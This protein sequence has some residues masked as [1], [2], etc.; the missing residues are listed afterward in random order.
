MGD[1]DEDHWSDDYGTCRREGFGVAALGCTNTGPIGVCGGF[2][3]LF[4][5]VRACAVC[6]YVRLCFYTYTS[7]SC[8]VVVIPVGLTKKTAPEDEA[9]VMST[10]SAINTT[11]RRFGIRSTLDVRHYTVGWRFADHELRG[12]PIRLEVGPRDVKAGKVAGCRRVDG[13]K[14]ELAL[15]GVDVADAPPAES[16]PPVATAVDAAVAFAV[17]AKGKVFAEAVL[18]A[19]KAVHTTMLAKATAERDS[20]LTRAS[21]WS[22]PS[23]S[24]T[25]SSLPT[26]VWRNARRR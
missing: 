9:A 3:C 16:Q 4:V 15:E 17:N 10:A 18:D 7:L 12:V 2:V 24:T 23:S 14:F 8:Q 1:D 22:Q 20:R 13:E 19:L 6:V 11:L 26:V 25:S 5:C 21:E